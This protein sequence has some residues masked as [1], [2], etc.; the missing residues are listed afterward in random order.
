[1]TMIVN[2]HWVYRESIECT[3]DPYVNKNDTRFT[4]WTGFI[5][6]LLCLIKSQVIIELF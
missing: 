2:E 1:M 3:I 6:E 4:D 5:N